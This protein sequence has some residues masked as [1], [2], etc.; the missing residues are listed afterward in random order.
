MI[1]QKTR[2]ESVRSHLFVAILV[3]IFLFPAGIVAVRAARKCLDA[4]GVGDWESACKYSREA[5]T[6]VIISTIL[7]GVVILFLVWLVYLYWPQLVLLWRNWRL[8]MSEDLLNYP[9]Y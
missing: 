4:Q 3:T 5:R 8:I 6:W 9:G 1:E 2:A 7:G